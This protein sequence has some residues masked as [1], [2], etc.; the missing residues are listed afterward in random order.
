MESLIDRESRRDPSDDFVQQLERI[1]ALHAAGQLTD[2]EFELAK[3]R[4]FA[5]APGEP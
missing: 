4:L 5:A 3:Q 1:A 2:S